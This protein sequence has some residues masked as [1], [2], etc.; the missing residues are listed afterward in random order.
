M[1]KFIAFFMIAVMLCALCACDGS[2]DSTQPVETE[3]TQATQAADE[4]SIMD[5]F[6]LGKWKCTQV[7]PAGD[8]GWTDD[9]SLVGERTLEFF[10]DHTA[11][12]VING[13]EIEIKEWKFV[14]Y[15]ESNALT[16]D[17]SG[18]GAV[19]YFFKNGK[20]TFDITHSNDVV[21]FYSYEKI[22]EETTSAE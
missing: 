6:I 12:A 8:E 15:D 19:K 3:A 9:A 4:L 13:E 10:E 1:K 21:D 11:K 18:Y 7:N 20:I 17:L 2:D 5:R 16:F 22:V 14:W